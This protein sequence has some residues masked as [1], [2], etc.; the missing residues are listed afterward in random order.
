MDLSDFRRLQQRISRARNAVMNVDAAGFTR[1]STSLSENKLIVIGIK[2]P[3]QLEDELLQLCVWIWS[4]KDYL[5]NL[6]IASTGIGQ[7]IE[8]IVNTTDSLA[9][10]ADIANRDK[11]G[12]LK[13]SRTGDFAKLTNVGFKINQTAFNSITID[14]SVVTF[15]IGKPSAA[16]LIASI[17]FEKG[18]R[19]V[20]DA[21]QVLENALNAWET[22]AF[23]L[24]GV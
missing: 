10:V 1:D 7:Q 11:H 4:M 2:S 19:P 23:P 16:T 13:K 14:G 15:D 22:Q 20:M 8:D 18:N 17:E 12:K 9:I 3:E 5:K 21:F 24:V 6:V